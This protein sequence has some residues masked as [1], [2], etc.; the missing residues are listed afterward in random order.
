MAPSKKRQKTNIGLERIPG[1][2]DKKALVDPP[3]VTAK[4]RFDKVTIPAAAEMGERM[5]RRRRRSGGEVAVSP[6]WLHRRA[7]NHN[8]LI[9]GGAK[10]ARQTTPNSVAKTIRKATAAPARN[11]LNNLDCKL[12]KN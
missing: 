1:V 2:L 12:I 10:V 9:R 6:N 5:M 8:L 4:Y 3:S 11:M 7:S